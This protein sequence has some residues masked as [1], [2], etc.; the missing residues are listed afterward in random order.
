MEVWLVADN[1]I[2][3]GKIRESLDRHGLS[4][5]PAKTIG[6]ETVEFQTD[7]FPSISGILLIAVTEVNASCFDAIR[8]LRASVQQETVIAL[9]ASNLDREAILTAM[10]LGC[11]DFLNF[12]LTFDAEV[13]EFLKRVQ[14]RSNESASR[15]I[16]V[17]PSQSIR[18]ANIFTT[19]LAA[20][21]A[22]NRGSCGVLDFFLQGGDL[23][24]L[25]KLAPRHTIVDLLNQPEK[26]DK[27]MFAQAISRQEHGIEL[28]AS[29][30]HCTLIDDTQLGECQRLLSLAKQTWKDVIL[31]VD[32]VQRAVQSQVLAASD[33]LILTIRPDVSALHRVQQQLDWLSNHDVKREQVHVVTMG[34]GYSGELSLAAVKKLL[35]VPSMHF[36]PDDQEAVLMSTN[37]GNPLVLELPK[38]KMAVAIRKFSEA[39]LGYGERRETAQPVSP[40]RFKAAALLA[41]NTIPFCK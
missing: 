24:L 12:C 9:I 5:P 30:A 28:L 32:N 37:I 13:A 36:I 14:L 6:L 3:A 40:N 41:L 33:D 18:D 20:M 22:A 7:Q 11:N 35:G 31:H 25:L 17:I 10:R 38:S 1:E 15:V 8:R 27:S 23:G 21:I 34:T 39:A 4:C 29:P 26:I 16:T 19:N 2:I